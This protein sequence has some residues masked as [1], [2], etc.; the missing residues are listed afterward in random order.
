MIEDRSE[1]GM[2]AARDGDGF[3]PAVD[4]VTCFEQV[5]AEVVVKEE[6]CMS[7]GGSEPPPRSEVDAGRGP[8]R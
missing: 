3:E 5:L 1:L 6:T 8:A 7:L 2:T 4:D